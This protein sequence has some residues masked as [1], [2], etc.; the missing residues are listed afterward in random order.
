MNSM[1]MPIALTLSV[2]LPTAV[3]SVPL[4][5]IRTR[6]Q[7]KEREHAR[8]NPAYKFLS[9]EYEPKSKQFSHLAAGQ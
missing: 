3:N 4:C 7:P 6:N 5:S 1:P 2:T 8:A 9:R